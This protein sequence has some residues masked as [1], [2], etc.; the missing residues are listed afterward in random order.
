MGRIDRILYRDLNFPIREVLDPAEQSVLEGSPKK[1]P[2]GC[3]LHDMCMHRKGY[4]TDTHREVLGAPQGPISR[5]VG[6]FHLQQV[7]GVDSSTDLSC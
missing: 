3:T 1:Q 2:K 4:I 6:P 7:I 5:S